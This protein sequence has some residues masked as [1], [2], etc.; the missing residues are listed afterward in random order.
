MSMV[1]PGG[2]SSP[3]DSAHFGHEESPEDDSVESRVSS[4]SEEAVKLRV[5]GCPLGKK[6]ADPFGDGEKGLSHV[7]LA[8]ARQHAI[9][10][11][12]RVA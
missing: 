1:F 9:E 11:L 4:S 3:G 8:T 12:A 10:I 7:N 5:S 2:Q 6:C